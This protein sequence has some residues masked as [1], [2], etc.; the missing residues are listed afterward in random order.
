MIL[1]TVR[2]L[3]IENKLKTII[4]ECNMN[5]MINT[6]IDICIKI[7]IN[8]E[9]AINWSILSKNRTNLHK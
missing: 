5:M 3:R 4:V 7:I 8:K 6:K 1:M 2:W 9:I